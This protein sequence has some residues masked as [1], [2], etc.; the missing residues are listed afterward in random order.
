MGW[1]DAK[2]RKALALLGAALWLVL[3]ASW[4]SGIHGVFSMSGWYLTFLAIVILF[5]LWQAFLKNEPWRSSRRVGER[6][7]PPLPQPKAADAEKYG[8]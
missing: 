7:A 1:S 3:A 4:L 5:A 6:P 8:D 2:I